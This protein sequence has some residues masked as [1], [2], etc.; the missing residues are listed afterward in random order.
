MQNK[1]ELKD[2]GIVFSLVS[3]LPVIIVYSAIFFVSLFFGE[4]SSDNFFY[5]YGF[6]AFLPQMVFLL[7]AVIYSNIKK[8]D[9]LKSTFKSKKHLNYKTILILIPLCF[10]ML[11]GLSVFVTLTM[12]FLKLFG[13]NPAD[14]ILPVSENIPQLILAITVAGICPA[15]CE[16]LIFRGIILN[17]TEKLGEVASII[18]GGLLFSLFHQ[19][20]QQTV[21]QFFCGMIFTFITIRT[22]SI[23]PAMVLHFINN[24]IS[25]VALHFAGAEAAAEVSA[26]DALMSE[27]IIAPLGIFVLAVCLMYFYF[28]KKSP[29]TA[30]NAQPA[31]T[32]D[33]AQTTAPPQLLKA[34]G[35][36]YLTLFAYSAVGILVC[37]AMWLLSFVLTIFGYLS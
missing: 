21:Y 36:D 22:M 25:V 29:D 1:F 32:P 23:L 35:N 14:T 7:T 8:V 10:G 15:V 9:L 5:T 26:K 34:N 6:S 12:E 16:E 19:S 13:Y 28:L 33:T 20:P 3:V 24:T 2:S 18:I 4:Q 31:I 11:Y 37:V 30:G 17:G 27:L